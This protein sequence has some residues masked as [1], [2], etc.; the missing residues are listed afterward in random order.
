MIENVKKQYQDAY[1]RYGN[2]LDAVFIPK[3]RQQERFSSLMTYVKKESFSILDYGCGLGQMANYIN[4]QFPKA[5]YH[6]VDI[7]EDFIS[8]NNAKYDFGRFEIIRNCYDIK[9]N[10]DVITAA[11]VFNLLYVQDIKQH[12][13]IV[14][15]NLIH[16][17]SKTIDILS[18]NFMT[19][20]VDFIQEGAFHQNI[21]ELYDFAKSKLTK[22]VAVD[23]S[24]MP[25][26]FTFHFF[27]DQN[28]LRP[29][30]IYNI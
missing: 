24:Y 15:D 27:K 13:Q 23:E 14:Y 16:L 20:Q 11:G 22:R 3:G 18:V 7:I 1:N 25:Y 21:S 10:Y 5:H 29:D 26:E 19:D 9:E 12:Q 30:N 28:I 2:S 17:F 8:E 6:G 4:Q